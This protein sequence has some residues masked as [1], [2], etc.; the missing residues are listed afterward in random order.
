MTRRKIAWF[1]IVVCYYGACVRNFTCPL[2]SLVIMGVNLYEAVR[3]QAPHQ[4]YDDQTNQNKPVFFLSNALIFY[5]RQCSIS[6]KNVPGQL[7]RAP[8]SG[9][10][11]TGPPTD[12]SEFLT[13]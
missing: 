5:P 1:S 7:P 8:A 9:E 4:H 3:A 10:G 11:R 13:D 12:V 6:K 2:F